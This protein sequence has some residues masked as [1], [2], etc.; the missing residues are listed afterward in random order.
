MHMSD[1]GRPAD[2]VVLSAVRAA[3][4][5]YPGVR[6]AEAASIPELTVRP[7]A[8]VVTDDFVSGPELRR[9]I[10]D[11]LGEGNAP[12]LVAILP[13]LPRT[14]ERELDL[15][16][17]RGQLAAAPTV[18]R[19]LRPR[20]AVERRLAEMWGVLF[21]LPDVGA[22]DDFL[23]LGGDSL[24]ATS[25]LTE[26]EAA[27]GVSVSLADLFELATIER[28]AADIDSRRSEKE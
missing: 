21:G 10:V 19:Y 22:R 4:L 3:L 6:D 17:L 20:S 9:H 14:A 25:V 18:Y 16:T 13:E 23:E 7:V 28:L 1:A 12:D 15:A 11:K 5:S 8:A 26:V 27:S 2:G 24:S